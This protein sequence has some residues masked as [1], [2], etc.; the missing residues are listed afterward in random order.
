[1]DR[2]NFSNF[3][4]EEA[5]KKLTLIIE[6]MEKE[7]LTL[8]DSLRYFEEGMELASYCRKLLTE[9]EQKVEILLQNGELVD[10][11]ELEEA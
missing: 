11:K 2:N 8:E 10:F 7:E 6:K 9:A 1:M 3:T 5:F 4:F